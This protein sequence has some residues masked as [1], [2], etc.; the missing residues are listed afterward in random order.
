MMCDVN[1]SVDHINYSIV[2]SNELEFRIIASLDTR[3]IS[4]LNVSY[5]S[6]IE[7]EELPEN[8][9]MCCIKIYFVRPGDRLWD[10]AKRYRSTPERIITENEL[11]GE[12]DICP[13]K[14]LII[15]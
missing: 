9:S 8:G 2:T 7:T 3:I 12:S 10:I 14:K 4:K 6:D 15:M 1:I 5:V 11:S 13:G